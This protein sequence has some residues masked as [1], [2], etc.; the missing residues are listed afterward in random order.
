MNA[1]HLCYILQERRPSSKATV[2]AQAIAKR[3]QGKPIERVGEYTR[4]LDTALPGKH[5]RLLYDS[6]K[7][8]EASILAQLR[9]GMTR[10]NGY[11]NRIEASETDQCTSSK[12]ERQ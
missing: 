8:L 2:L 11:L 1:R 9:T 12:S 4:K 6:F 3:K 5:T 10:L 7:W